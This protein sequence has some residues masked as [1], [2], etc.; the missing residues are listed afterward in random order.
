MIS[1][2]YLSYNYC[3]IAGS[4]TVANSLATIL[5][6]IVSNPRVQKKLV[7]ELEEALGSTE[8]PTHEQI[9]GIQYLIATVDEG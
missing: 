1:M 9:K 3:R 6:L 8:P 4:D 2:D 7:Q 5:N